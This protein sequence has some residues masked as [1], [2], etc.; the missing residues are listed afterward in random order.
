M[1][2]GIDKKGLHKE[3]SEVKQRQKIHNKA[4]GKLGQRISALKKELKSAREKYK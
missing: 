1:V 3:A 2:L 4:S